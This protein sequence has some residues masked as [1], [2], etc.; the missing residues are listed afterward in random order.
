MRIARCLSSTTGMPLHYRIHVTTI[1]SSMAGMA[2]YY[3]SK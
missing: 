3:G 2:S 1:R